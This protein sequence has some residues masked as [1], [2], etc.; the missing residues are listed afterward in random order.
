MKFNR[1]LLR[2]AMTTI[3]YQRKWREISSEEGEFVDEVIQEL[4]DL[5]MITEVQH[6]DV[7]KEFVDTIISIIK[8]YKDEHTPTEHQFPL[9]VLV[10]KLNRE[11]NK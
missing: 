3:Q 6:I 11:L 1:Q 5:V 9:V 8:A 4:K 10:Y 2:V 7:D